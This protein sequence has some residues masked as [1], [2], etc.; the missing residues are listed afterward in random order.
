MQRITPTDDI[1]IRRSGP[2]QSKNIR[3]HVKKKQTL[4]RIVPALKERQ[5]GVG[6]AKKRIKK[7]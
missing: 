4:P 1:F 6:A 7:R 5:V 3:N 2:L